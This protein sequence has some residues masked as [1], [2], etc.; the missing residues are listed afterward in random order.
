MLTG[1]APF[2]MDPLVSPHLAKINFNISVGALIRP[3]LRYDMFDQFMVLK[4]DTI[5]YET[6]STGLH[7]FEGDTI[8]GE[9]N[10]F[11]SGTNSVRRIHINGVHFR[12]YQVGFS[13][14][15]ERGWTIVGLKST[16][17]QPRREQYR[18]LSFCF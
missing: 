1:T 10:S 11:Q 16:G 6:F 9:D 17:S 4:N 7:V 14:A 3:L 13:M 12:V 2:K 18:I 8:A 5:V 15:G